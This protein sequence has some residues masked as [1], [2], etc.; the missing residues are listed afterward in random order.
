MKAWSITTENGEVWMSQEGRFAI[1]D[2]KKNALKEKRAGG[3][4]G[5]AVIQPITIRS[6]RPL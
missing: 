1:F 5:K 4:S 6:R 3:F 2:T